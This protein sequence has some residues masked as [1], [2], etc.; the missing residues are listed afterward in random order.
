M[1]LNGIKRFIPDVGQQ[2][3]D[4]QFN[5]RTVK[6]LSLYERWFNKSI[7][8]LTEAFVLFLH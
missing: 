8:M 6:E 3:I 4:H 1:A 2:V 5:D 7:L